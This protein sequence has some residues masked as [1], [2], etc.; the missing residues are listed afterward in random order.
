MKQINWFEK[1][2]GSGL[3]TGYIPFASGTF[4]SLVALIIYLIIPKS[5]DIR[6]L[7]FL[8]ILFTIVGVIVSSKFE[9][10]YGKDPA[11]C[12]ID[13]W[14]G[15]WISFI[16]LPKDLLWISISFF[17]WRFLDVVKPFPARHSE[18]LPSGFGI[19]ADDIISG[20]YT[21]L[22]MQIIYYLSN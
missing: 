5:E 20:F 6:A 17:I 1:I 9:K 13:E 12:T 19:M 7:I 8:I 11:E 4:G 2:I 15:T 22:I 3:Y 16:N 21:F 10:I 18:K 14:V